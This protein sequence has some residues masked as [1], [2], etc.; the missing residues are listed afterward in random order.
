MT[1][2]HGPSLDFLKFTHDLPTDFSSALGLGTL[3]RRS[4]RVSGLRCDEPRYAILG[5]WSCA[6]A[7]VELATAVEL[8]A[9]ALAWRAFTG[10]C[11]AP[12]ALPVRAI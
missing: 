10:T 6:A 1:L 2:G 7:A 5:P 12:Y 9:G 4:T 8:I 3:N 11:L